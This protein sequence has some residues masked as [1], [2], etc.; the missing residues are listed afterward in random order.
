MSTRLNLFALPD[1]TIVN[2]APHCDA[3]AEKFQLAD[4][5]FVIAIRVEPET[6]D[7]GAKARAQALARA[8]HAAR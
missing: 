6:S 7:T 8:V 3:P 1:G 5:S 2:L 4:G